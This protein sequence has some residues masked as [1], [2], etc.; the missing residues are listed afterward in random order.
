MKNANKTV[1][2]QQGQTFKR[3]ML[4][5][6]DSLLFNLLF[7]Y[8][9]TAPPPRDFQEDSL[10]SSAPFHWSEALPWSSVTSEWNLFV[11]DFVFRKIIYEF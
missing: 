8:H 11:L 1:P 6:R 7:F 5:A 4:T 9:A 3:R 2:P 10:H